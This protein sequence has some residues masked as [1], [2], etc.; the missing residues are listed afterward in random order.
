MFPIG[1]TGQAFAAVAYP[2][3]MFLPTKVAGAWFGA[4]ERGKATTIGMFLCNLIYVFLG[5]MANPLGVL[6][7]NV[8]APQLVKDPSHVLYLNIIVAIPAI[9][10]CLLATFG[11]NRSEPKTPP[12]LSAAQE[13]MRF[14][15]G[16]IFSGSL[17]NA[18]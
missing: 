17:S 10:V 16:K 11:V 1:I 7:A 6:L 8:L 13:Q 15:D 18:F 9:I 2:F 5:V 3:I 12:T 14:L 4:D